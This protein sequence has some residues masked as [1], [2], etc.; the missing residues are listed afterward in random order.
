MSDINCSC[1]SVCGPLLPISC[2]IVIVATVSD[3]LPVIT[4]CLPLINKR[5]LCAACILELGGLIKKAALAV[6][7]LFVPAVFADNVNVI[8]LSTYL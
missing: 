8:L 6:T 5:L 3:V 7:V 2:K 4:H 1:Q